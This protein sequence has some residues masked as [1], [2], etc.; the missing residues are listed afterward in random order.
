VAVFEHSIGPSD[1]ALWPMTAFRDAAPPAAAAA[2]VTSPPPQPQG[3]AVV[4]L[5]VERMRLAG[6]GEP[7]AQ[8]WLLSRVMQPVR[9]V[10]RAFLRRSA[11]A[12]DAAQI[13]LMAI[14]QSASTYRGEAAVEGWA[15]RIAVRATLRF[16][17]KERRQDKPL[18][19]EGE[20]ALEIAAPSEEHAFEEL[21]RDVR[22]YLKELPEA[23]RNALI[24]HHALGYSIEEIGELTEVSPDTVKSR[25]RLGTAAL[26][27]SVQREIAFGRGRSS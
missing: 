20:G 22:D 5:D 4:S 11:D 17:Q 1:W 9:R 24:L 13:A 8:A 18:T 7:K 15:K 3:A 25:L 27:K 26:R 16:I 10:A 2:P 14:L 12:D 19:A 6:E 21:P 23:Q